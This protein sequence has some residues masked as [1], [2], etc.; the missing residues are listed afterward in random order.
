[1]NILEYF[2]RE[3]GPACQIAGESNSESL[4]PSIDTMYSFEEWSNK[5][6]TAT[7]LSV[8]ITLAPKNYNL[9][10]SWEV[11][12]LNQANRFIKWMSMYCNKNN[13]T[14]YFI[15]ETQKSGPLH[16]HGVINVSSPAER[17]MLHYKLNRMFGRN[18]V[19]Q[20]K[21]HLAWYK[22]LHKENKFSC[23]ESIGEIVN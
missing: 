19:V 16:W 20:I 23:Y 11:T 13:N 9:Q 4:A 5:F 8:T 21:N 14:S 15:A 1:M 18:E 3:L 2:Q 12:R 17:D 6:I 10:S 7:S 22:Y